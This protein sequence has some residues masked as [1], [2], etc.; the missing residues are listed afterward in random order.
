MPPR[1]EYFLELRHPVFVTPALLTSAMKQKGAYVFK[2][3]INI[4]IESV[5]F[6]EKIACW[7]PAMGVAVALPNSDELLVNVTVKDLTP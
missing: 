3:D 6:K 7:R 4:T 1:P 5:L 2:V